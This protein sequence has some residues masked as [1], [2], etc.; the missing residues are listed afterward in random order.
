MLRIAF[1]ASL[2][3]FAASAA[4][5]AP[6]PD[7][8]CTSASHAP[9]RSTYLAP[10][11]GQYGTADN[12]LDISEHCGKLFVNGHGFAMV[13]LK[14]E[15]WGRMFW[16]A[17]Y[18]RLMFNLLVTPT[19]VQIGKDVLAR[20]DFG[21]EVE[22]RIH[23]AVHADPDKVR[24][25]AMAAT[26]PVDPHPKRA[27]DLAPLKS[28]DPSIKVDTIYAT[29][30]NFMGIPI[31]EKGGAYMQRDAAQAVA[32][33][34]QELHKYGYGLWVTD[35]YRP[36]YA[37]KMFWDATPPEDHNFVADPA[38]GSRHN[39]GCAVDLTLYDL[40]TGKPVEMTGRIDEMSARS[41]ADYDGGTTRQRW[42][43]ALL[44]R[45]M[46]AQ[47]FTVY[48]DEWWHFDYKDW[49]DYAVGTAT[50]TD[51]DAGKAH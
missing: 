24:K 48:T 50:Y 20:H 45:E 38:H 44:K 51:L 29:T 39:R 18:Q 42:L 5:A 26:A 15:N 21:A 1:A 11:V 9:A 30:R 6:P 2:S 28:L 27:S 34:S 49:A 37:T 4:M 17:G 47:G 31:Y 46:E 12:I 43:R 16:D 13:E 33:A 41:I 22:A 3:L 25:A 10:M 40:K 32:R 35:A 14:P 36:W 23:A 19:T 7:T 8:N